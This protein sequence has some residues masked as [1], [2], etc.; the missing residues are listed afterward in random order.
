MYPLYKV[1]VINIPLIETK[2]EPVL[3]SEDNT[4]RTHAIK[5]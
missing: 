3:I 1:P 5:V 4:N 2:F